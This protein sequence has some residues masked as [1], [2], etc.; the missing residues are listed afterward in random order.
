M[1]GAYHSLVWAAISFGGVRPARRLYRARHLPTHVALVER[2]G[3]AGRYRSERLRQI[4]LNQRLARLYG[5]A[6]SREDVARIGELSQFVV[7]RG[8]TA[9]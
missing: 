9:G 2:L 4:G 3:A 6:V 8:K 5:G 7:Q 1:G